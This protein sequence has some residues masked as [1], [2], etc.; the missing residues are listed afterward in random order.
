LLLSAVL[1]CRTLGFWYTVGNAGYPIGADFLVFWS[2]AR[3]AIAGH[4]AEL[5]SLGITLPDRVLPFFYP[6]TFL[7]FCLPF[8]LLPVYDALLRFTLITGVAYVC[9]TSRIAGWAWIPALAFPAVLF[10]VLAGQNGLLT[11]AI[12]GSALTLLDR[13]PRTAG[14]LLGMMV[15]KP[16][17]AIVLPLALLLSR[18]WQVLAYAAISA[19]LLCLASGMILGWDAWS[20]FL[21][22]GSRS[23]QYM[24]TDLQVGKLK[25]I[26]GFA[27]MWGAS[28][29]AAQ[30]AQAITAVMAISILVWAEL[31]HA[32]ATVERSLI[33]V[34][35]LL[36]TPYTLHYDAVMMIFPCLWLMAGWVAQKSRA[37]VMLVLAT[38]LLVIAS[39]C[40]P[41]LPVDIVIRLIWLV[42]LARLTAASAPAIRPTQGGYRVFAS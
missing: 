7:L 14:L 10:N 23:L 11:A 30:M 19:L 21:A 29:A 3:L 37:E 25:S 33:V 1:V 13:R 24:A 8:G 15:I 41:K 34:T 27:R 16:H 20:Q 17:L 26:F 5:Y 18:R 6:P 32:P 31:R 35:G 39:L 38:Y 40:L 4:L 22:S 12:M 28:M 2:A 9:A 42:Y 36:A